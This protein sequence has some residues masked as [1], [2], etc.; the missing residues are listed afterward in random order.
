V[1]FLSEVLIEVPSKGL[2][3]SKIGDGLGGPEGARKG[4]RGGPFLPNLSNWS[5]VP[6]AKGEGRTSRRW[7]GGRWVTERR[8]KRETGRIIPDEQMQQG[9]ANRRRTKRDLQS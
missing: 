8:T 1:R 3:D 5:A 6:G 2:E 7:T 9:C 4:Y